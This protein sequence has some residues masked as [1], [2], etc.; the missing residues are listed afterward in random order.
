MSETSLDRATVAIGE[1][2][3]SVRSLHSEVVQSE[4]L[5]TTK[6]KW[7]QRLLYVMVPAIVLLMLLAI[8]NFVLLSKINAAA[9]DARSTNTLLLGCLQPGTKCSDQNRRQ[10][11]A[12]LD[13]IRQTQFA[14]ALCQ[15]LNPID[16]DPDGTGVVRCVQQYYPNFTLPPK[17]GAGAK[18]SATP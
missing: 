1:L 6:I 16:K 18:P 11:A 3:T 8:S 7:I 12:A 10:T 4:T 5:R 14:I 9:S 15:R 13:Q 2:S 17:V